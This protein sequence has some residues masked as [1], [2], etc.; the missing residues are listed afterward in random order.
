MKRAPRIVRWCM[1]ALLV[2]GCAGLPPRTPPPPLPARA[3]LTDAPGSLPAGD[4]PE[5]RW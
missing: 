5:A 2:A 3:A 1:P 4:W